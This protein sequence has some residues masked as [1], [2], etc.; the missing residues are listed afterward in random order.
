MPVED[1]HGARRH[2][3]CPVCRQKKR[4]KEA[5]RIATGCCRRCDAPAMHFVKLCPKHIRQEAT[6]KHRQQRLQEYYVL[7]WLPVALAWIAVQR[8]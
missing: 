3:T 4:E 7:R 2:T 5:A 8:C 1:L 6:K